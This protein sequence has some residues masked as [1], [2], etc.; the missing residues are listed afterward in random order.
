MYKRLLLNNKISATFKLKTV[1][2]CFFVLSFQFF[3]TQTNV[4]NNP[5]NDTI[6]V[7]ITAKNKE[8]RGLFINENYNSISVDAASSGNPG[9]MEYQGV[10]T[11]SKNI[12]FKRGPYKEATNN[13]GE[14]L[15]LVHGLALL[16]KL[17]SN[18]IVYSDSIT[19]ISWVKKKKCQ[20]KLIPNK[21]NKEVFAAG[22]LSKVP[23][24]WDTISLI[25][26]SFMLS[27][28]TYTC[29]LFTAGFSSNIL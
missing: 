7:L 27:R 10:D 9:K 23:R 26:F 8:L 20:T 22:Y 29:P 3:W 17:K 16:K 15:G 21:D 11:K 24:N 1:T 5:S 2:F 13:I 25:L 18:Q 12:L 14:F 4:V 28:I 6:V 19:A